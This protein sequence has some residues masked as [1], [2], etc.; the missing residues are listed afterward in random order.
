MPLFPSNIIPIQFVAIVIFPDG[1]KCVRK[2]IETI[3]DA[4]IWII[5]QIYLNKERNTKNNFPFGFEY[6]IIDG[7]VIMTPEQI[8]LPERL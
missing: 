3:Y 5:K 4:K 6:S 1:K 8:N 2:L 7:D